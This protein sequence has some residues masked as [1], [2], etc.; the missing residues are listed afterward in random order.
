MSPRHRVNGAG[1]CVNTHSV[2]LKELRPSPC[3]LQGGRECVRVRPRDK[4]GTAA[5]TVVAF[6]A[7]CS[8]TF[9]SMDSSCASL[10][11]ARW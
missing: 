11:C 5:R 7:V 9:S 3:Y 6:G 8:F 10:T 2:V 4:Q 1:A